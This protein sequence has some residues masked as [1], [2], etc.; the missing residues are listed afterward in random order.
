[1]L[2][3]CLV[4]MAYFAVQQTFS[5]SVRYHADLR[6]AD[7]D[8]VAVEVSCE[9]DPG[10]TGRFH[11]PMTIPGTY[12]RHDYGRYISDFQAL[13]AQGQALPVVRE[14]E[15]T[16]VISQHQQV[17]TLRYK[18][19]DTFDA[20]VKKNKV[21]EPAG[22]NIQAGQNFLINAAGFFGYWEGTEALPVEVSFDKPDAMYGTTVLDQKK[23]SADNQTFIANSYHHLLDCPVMFCRPDTLSFQVANT[24]VAISVFN[25]SGRNLSADIYEEIKTA[26]QATAD[27]L[28]GKLPVDRYAFILYIKDYTAYEEMLDGGQPSIGQLIKLFRALGNQG[29]GALEHGN[30]SVYFLPDLGGL[31][32]LLSLRETCT[33]EFLHILTPLTLHSE[34]IGQFNYQNPIMSRHLWLYEGVTEYFAGITMAK[35]GVIT[36]QEYLTDILRDK[37]RGARSYPDD[38]PFTTMSA[39]VLE[40]P[41]KKQYGQVYVRGA[42][43]GAMLDIEIM[44]LT[45]CQKNLMDVVQTLGGR[46]GADSSFDEAGFIQEL[47]AEVHPDL[48]QFFDRYITGTTPLDVAGS[49]AHAGIQYTRTYT[50]QGPLNPVSERYNDLKISRSILG[51]KATVSKVGKKEFAGLQVGDEFEPARI[52]ELL[53]LPGGEFVPEGTTIEIPLVRA[54]KEIK[55]PH[56]VRYGTVTY[57]DRLVQ[58]ADPT[59]AQRQVR[60]R[61]LT[62]M[63]P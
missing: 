42:L 39:Q 55:L 3:F 50:G 15:N 38:M 26:M 30:S 45:G 36:P 51:S 59:P 5:Q 57:E 7:M 21:F 43:M 24:R 25:E 29:F 28:G 48:Q 52:A 37:I 20:E 54:G 32:T 6:K 58:I 31:S 17:R 62:L 41:W 61:W 11:F 2:R 4:L 27:F 33:H 19:D 46:Y 60:D 23:Y 35:G 56:V 1:M 8:Q 14:G 16:F 63:R 49:L 53:I 22:T 10:G 13:D 12:A 34:H 47:V 44:R 40:N 9:G 18:V